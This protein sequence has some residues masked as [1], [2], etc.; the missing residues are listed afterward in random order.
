MELE[1]FLAMVEQYGVRVEGRPNGIQM[2]IVT[3]RARNQTIF[4]RPQ[5]YPTARKV[6]HD[7]LHEAKKEQRQ[8]DQLE[9]GF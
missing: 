1:D 3:D 9:F 5:E 4:L 6:L 2:E 7:T 8:S